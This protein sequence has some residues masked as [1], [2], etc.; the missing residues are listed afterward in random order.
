[1]ERDGGYTLVVTG[2]DTYAVQDSYDEVMRALRGC[3]A[4]LLGGDASE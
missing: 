4:N 2:T 1:M 3:R